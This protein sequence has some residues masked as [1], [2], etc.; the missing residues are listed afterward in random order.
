KG[1]NKANGCIINTLSQITANPLQ[2]AV[3]VSKSN[4]TNDLILQSGIFNV[5]LLMDETPFELFR[6]FG[7]SSG[8]DQDK[9]PN[10]YSSELAPNGV[11]YLT[12]HSH[13]VISG[14]VKQSIDC[15]SH[16]IH[17][18]EV[19]HA[20]ALNNAKTV[21]YD[22][23]QEHIKPRPQLPKE[24]KGY[25]CQICAY[26]YEGETLPEDFICPL[27]KHGPEAFKKIG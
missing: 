26:H 17:L 20:V 15:G 5:S 16:M 6:H 8:R 14:K 23:Y 21:T 25:L 19:T 13:G 4:Y 11:P 22:Y 27:C 1:E 18:A 10:P 9:F 12:Q 2:V 7:Y 3:T 24:Q